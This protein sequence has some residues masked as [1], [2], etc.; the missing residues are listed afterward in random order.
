[1]NLTSVDFSQ[2]SIGWLDEMWGQLEHTDEKDQPP[3]EQLAEQCGL[4]DESKLASVYASHYLLPLFEPPIGLSIPVDRRLTQYLPADFCKENELVPLAVQ[5][6]SLEVAIASPSALLLA[7]DV[8]RISGLQMRPLFARATVVRK[9][10]DELYG[11]LKP[12]AQSTGAVVEPEATDVDP[13]ENTSAK[14]TPQ[15]P[16]IAKPVVPSPMNLTAYDLKAA[17]RATWQNQLVAESGLT[18]YC[19]R[20][21]L[22][23]NPLA[24]L[25]GVWSSQT[26]GRPA[27]KWNPLQRE[28]VESDPSVVIIPDLNNRT[29][30]EVCL[31]SVLQGERVFA[32]VH[33]RDPVSAILRLRAWGQIGHLLAEQINLLIHQNGLSRSECRS[34]EID[35]TRRSALASENDMG[36]L[37]KLFPS[38][39]SFLCGP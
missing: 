39:G 15:P 33:A 5:D 11:E 23:K 7:D 30:A 36:R 20:K 16:P 6:H 29:S 14:R 18:I 32:V 9:A 10:C 26:H 3:E 38:T 31:H 25:W 22:D 35:D 17:E 8:R 12:P 2:P 27:R 13:L 4:T 19:G 28:L 1:M 34:I 24:R 21:S 37:Q